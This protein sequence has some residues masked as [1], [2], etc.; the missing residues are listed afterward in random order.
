MNGGLTNQNMPN[1]KKYHSWLVSS[2]A[3]ITPGYNKAIAHFE[4]KRSSLLKLIS[5][6]NE[7]IAQDFVNTLNEEVDKEMEEYIN[8]DG[9][10]EV[11]RMLSNIKEEF[12]NAVTDKM[13]GEHPK[14]VS[15]LTDRLESLQ[16][17]KRKIETK[18]YYN[19]M[20]TQLQDY[21]AKI[22]G[23]SDQEALLKKIAEKSGSTF[24]TNTDVQNQ[25]RGYMRQMTMQM[26]TTGQNYQFQIN[27]QHFKNALK[28]YVKEE[29]LMDPL[30][31]TLKQFLGPDKWFLVES[32]G[33]LGTAEDLTIYLP[34]GE[35][36]EHGQADTSMFGIQSKSWA[37]AF[38]IPKEDR[39]K[40]N[41]YKLEIGD[42]AQI[43]R[44]GVLTDE[45]MYYWHAGLFQAMNN[46]ID[47]LGKN[48]VLFSTGSAAY[49]TADMLFKLKQTKYVFAFAKPKGKGKILTPSVSITE[50]EDK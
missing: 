28:G 21:L 20:K 29:V 10:S 34:N 4:E 6:D 3:M 22:F 16:G 15:F 1:W 35:I 40:Y 19:N 13:L 9:Q 33:K 47:V 5:K 31:R 30:I 41:T 18:N 17:N 23:V 42:R 37:F 8:Q 24:G 36:N 49:W 14:D 12:Y 48:T 45:D 7:K 26:L 46:L 2:H 38:D 32:T 11:D 44:N 27:L 39:Y 25:L 43:L 50:H